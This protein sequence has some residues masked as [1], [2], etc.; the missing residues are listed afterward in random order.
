M[1]SVFYESIIINAFVTRLECNTH[2]GHST[3]LEE[4]MAVRI[5]I[6][7]TVSPEKAKELIPL[8]R[9][10]RNLAMKQPGYIS[11]ETLRRLDRPDQFLIISTWHR[12]KDWENWV[13]TKDRREIQERIDD[14]LGGETVYEI[15]HY[16]FTE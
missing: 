7:R 15:Y 3:N 6:K 10:M 8:F 11:G 13:K 14:L 5:L 9:E 12:S 2:L 16:G 4:N 1:N